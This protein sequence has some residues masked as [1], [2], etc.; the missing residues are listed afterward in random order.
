MLADIIGIISVGIW[1]YLLVARG[2]FWRLRKDEILPEFS[3][4]PSI[5]IIVP[6]RNEADVIWKSVGSL[7]S[8][9]YAGTFHVVV[10]NDHSTDA[11]AEIVAKAAAELG[12]GDRL[13]I[14]NARPLPSGWMGKPWAV[15]EGIQSAP[16]ADYFLLTDADIVHD[17]GSLRSLVARAEE[18]GLDMVSSIV[19]FRCQ[20]LAERTLIPAFTFFFFMLY[21]PAWVNNPKYST[22][23]AAGGCILIRSGALAQIGGIAAIGDELIDDCALARAVKAKGKIWLGATHKATSVREYDNWSDIAQMISRSAFHQLDH[24]AWLLAGTIAGMVVTYVAPPALAGLGGWPSALGLSAWLAMSFAY[25][26][27]LRSYQRSFLWAPLLP[28]V[29]VFYLGAT[30]ASA[31]QYWLGRGGEWKGRIQDAG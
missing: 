7:L 11:T 20:S 22:A 12:C 13:T 8:Q 14:V 15:S 10:A 28:L 23:A 9:N 31:V 6:A 24:S 5:A 4:F 16:V 26:P 30:I 18:G 3:Q 19:T 2:G 17:P 29:A 1:A 27:T 21:P 25:W